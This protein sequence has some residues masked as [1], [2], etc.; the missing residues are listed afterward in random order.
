VPRPLQVTRKE[1][2]KSVREDL[3][4]MRRLTV[5]C[6]PREE[7]LRIPEGGDWEPELSGED[8][9]VS[10]K[11]ERGVEELDNLQRSPRSEVL[12]MELLRPHRR[13][14]RKWLG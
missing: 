4:G 12:L 6:E 1:I 14:H 10:K 9:E 8:A 13:R 11:E 7:L 3:K 5:R 2:E